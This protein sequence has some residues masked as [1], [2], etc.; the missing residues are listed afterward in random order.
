MAMPDHVARL[1]AKVDNDLLFLPSAACVIRDAEERI[2]LVR[3]VE[4]WWS[5]PGGFIDVGETP[6][7]AARREARE[8]V[9]VEVELVG[10]AGSSADRSS[11]A[12]TR[13]VTRWPGS[14]RSSTRGS[15]AAP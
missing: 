10:I 1:R 6:A 4:G 13:T 8:E 2:L 11:T 14:W 9:S 7:E 5:L 3:H 15:R 12:S